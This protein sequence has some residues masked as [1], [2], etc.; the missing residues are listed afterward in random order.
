MEVI[1]FILAK[2][3]TTLTR[4]AEEFL[5]T[6]YSFHIRDIPRFRPKP[7]GSTS[8]LESAELLTQCVGSWAD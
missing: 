8:P 5:G 1:T 3:R 7:V 2:P 4:A 6:A